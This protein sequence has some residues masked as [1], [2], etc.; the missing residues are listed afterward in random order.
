M[1]LKPAVIR[2]L[3]ADVA[4]LIRAIGSKRG[5]KFVINPAVANAFVVK[6]PDGVI[7]GRSLGHA[8]GKIQSPRDP[9]LIIGTNF[10][11]EARQTADVEGCDLLSG[12][13]FVWTD[14]TYAQRYNP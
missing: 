8:L 1:S 4:S 6:F 2:D 3:P 10:T 14:A 13:E 9:T 5:R 11:L 7:T 12:R